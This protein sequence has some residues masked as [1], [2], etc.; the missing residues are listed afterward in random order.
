MP[1]LSRRIFRGW[2]VVAAAFTVLFVVYGIQFSFGTFVTDIV[3][4]TGWSESR[5]QLIF[6][7]YIFGYS[8]LSAV[9]G[10][11]TDRLG[12]QI[13]VASGSIVLLAGYLVWASA[14]NLWIVFLGLGVIAPIGMSGSWVPC[15]ATAVRWFIESRGLA[16]AITTAGGSLGNMVVPP[17]AAILVDEYGW[18]TA[19]RIL[20]VV[21]CSIMFLAAFLFRRDPESVGEVPDGLA[22]RAAAAAANPADG[23]VVEAPGMT[24]GEATKTAAFWLMFGMYALTF[25]AVFVPFAHVH[26]FAVDLGVSSVQASTVISAIGAGGLAG[27]LLAGPIS[28]RIDR[29]YVVRLAFMIET[30][31]FFGLAF[32]TGLSVLYPSAVAFGFAYGA[33]V[34]VFPALVGDYF[35]RAHS[36]AIVGRIFATA[37]SMAAVGPY[38]AQ[39]LVDSS[40]S[41]RVAF[42][43][44]GVANA[45]ALFMATRLPLSRVLVAAPHSNE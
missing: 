34:T 22:R 33:S 19:I 16:I 4:D 2:I 18:R 36:G 42:I 35:G 29:R 32:S 27:R 31:A 41:Y 9:S 7:T 44:A 25:T 26:Q 20:A 1:D 28:D 15:N 43:L 30:A 5:L 12:P 6:A 37:G 45:A 11:L 21:G 23:E 13:V 39:L 8:A 14:S 38:V 24:I 10:T 17:L 40:G 3:D